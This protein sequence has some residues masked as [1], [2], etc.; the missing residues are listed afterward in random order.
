MAKYPYELTIILAYLRKLPGVGKKSAERFA[1]ELLSWNKEE[2]QKFSSQLYQL[3]EKVHFCSDCGC[4]MSGTKCE[5]CD[6]NQRHRDQI[7]IISSPRE[8]Y[9][10]D[11]MRIYKGLYHV[12]GNLLSPLTGK[13][14]EQNKVTNL[15]HRIKELTIKEVI[16]ALDSTIEGDA[17]SLFLKKELESHGLH[18]SRL[19]FGLP[20]GS[21]LE[22]IDEGTL[23]QAFLGR[24]QF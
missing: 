3:K 20:L 7:C 2:V 6:P 23:A 24:K 15:I 11:E 13:A 16:L 21:S 12:I 19:A 1:F 4:L 14:I 8:A 5:F 18:I 9:V 10:F 17:T 22:Y